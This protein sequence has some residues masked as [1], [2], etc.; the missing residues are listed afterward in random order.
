M[1]PAGAL[2]AGVLWG[3]FA[4]GLWARW[5]WATT[6]FLHPTVHPE[7][8]FRPPWLLR[9]TDSSVRMTDDSHARIA[10]ERGFHGAP[11][12][13]ETA[14][15]GLPSG[16]RQAVREAMRVAGFQGA[17]A[18][19]RRL[20][21]QRDP[22]RPFPAGTAG[23]ALAAAFTW[24]VPRRSRGVCLV[25]TCYRLRAPLKTAQWATLSPLRSLARTTSQPRGG[26]WG[27]C[28]R[29]LDAF[30][31]TPRGTLSPLR[32]LACTT[33]QPRGGAWAVCR[34]LLAPFLSAPRETLSPLLLLEP[35]MHRPDSS[36][37][38]PVSCTL[39]LLRRFPTMKINCAASGTRPQWWNPSILS[40]GVRG[41]TSGT[42]LVLEQRS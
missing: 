19:G 40:N 25:A 9:L 4:R 21:R 27:A 12:L 7:A 41:T 33:P 36:G 32:S 15:A 11:R 38:Q 10:A 6:S 24:H 37:S 35:T 3:A 18:S 17:A 22:P 2:T 39:T 29:L 5:S 34:H 23:D 31:T 13:L 20:G 8:H 30:L 26:S 42:W 28:H 1:R 14:L 16:L